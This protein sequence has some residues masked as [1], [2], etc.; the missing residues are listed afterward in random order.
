MRKTKLGCKI[1]NSWKNHE[2]DAKKENS[3][4]SVIQIVKIFSEDIGME[5]GIEKCAI[6]FVITG[7]IFT[8]NISLPRYVQTVQKR[9]WVGLE[10]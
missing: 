10:R 5:L 1:S 6:L 8:S 9:C 2:F 3:L 7:N 4:N